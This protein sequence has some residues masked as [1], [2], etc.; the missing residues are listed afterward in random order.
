MTNQ[1]IQKV[2]EKLREYPE[3]TYSTTDDSI[4]VNPRDEN[5]FLVSLG[6]GPRDIIVS[7]DFWHEHFDNDEVDKALDCFAF[8][9]SDSC[10]LTIEYRGQK[11][12][13]WTMESFENGHW[14][15]YSTTGL[16]NFN[17][18]S[19]TRTEHF[20]NRLIKTRQ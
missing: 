2:I 17:F 8:M 5:G 9:L 7:S 6:V 18:W 3:V 19:P 15:R 20:Q 12:K 13:R 16:F 4:T 11:P 10:R 14:M 1:T